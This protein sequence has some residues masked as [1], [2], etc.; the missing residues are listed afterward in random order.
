VIDLHAHLLPGYDD[1]VRSLEEARE[2]ARGAAAEGVTAIAATPH[3]RADYPTTAERMLRGVARLNADFAA[4][5]IDVSVLAGGEL[6]ARRVWELG[7]EEISAF[8]LAGS[9]RWVLLETP[10]RGWPDH[11]ERTFE[12][13]R[14]HGVHT[15]LA[16]PE[17]NDAVQADP[18]RLAALVD[19]GLRV[20]VTAASVDGR[21]G[22]RPRACAAGLLARGLVHVLATDAHGPLVRAAGLTAAVTALADDELAH[23]LTV[24]WPAAIV[25][26]EDVD[27]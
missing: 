13:L 3:V 18:G 11:L 26:G 5:G 15:L 25:N 12:L 17:R 21:L 22:D 16:H 27:P 20:Q 9:G 6:D 19:R 23:R 8:T 14:R 7:P 10:Y 4:Q 24:T 1:G 2:L